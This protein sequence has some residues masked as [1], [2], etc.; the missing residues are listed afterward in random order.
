[1]GED[2]IAIQLE[3]HSVQIDYITKA[4]DETNKKIDKVS[5]KIDD[6]IDSVDV[7]YVK[8]DDFNFWR[9]ILVSGILLSIAGGVLLALFT[10]FIK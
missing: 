1:M 7:K 9:G 6:F 10:H 5:D 2:T 3:R 4:V 8:K